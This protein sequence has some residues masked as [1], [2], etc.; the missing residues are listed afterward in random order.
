[1]C[2]SIQ[3]VEA[4]MEGE[5]K[6]VTIGKKGLGDNGLEWKYPPHI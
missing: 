3:E 6:G 4:L 1:M 2:K 5:E